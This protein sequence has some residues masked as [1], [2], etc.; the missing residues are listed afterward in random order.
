MVVTL[1]GMVIVVRLEQ[2]KNAPTPMLVTLL[3]VVTVVRLEQ[4]KNA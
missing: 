4:L 2:F 1:L 3:E